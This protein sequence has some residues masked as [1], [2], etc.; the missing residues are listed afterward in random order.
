MRPPSASDKEIDELREL[1]RA[2]LT[3]TRPSAES[4]DVAGILRAVL[5]ASSDAI[6]VKDLEGRYILINSSGARKLGRE[7][8]AVLGRDDGE[9]FPAESSTRMRERDGA[10][11]RSGRPMTY[12][13]EDFVAGGTRVWQS[14]KIPLLDREGQPVG[15][16]GISRDITN[17]RRMEEA[18]LA[19]A[20]QLEAAQAQLVEKE[21]LAA[22][23]QLTA[24]VAHE[25]RNP[26][27]AIVNAVSLLRQ[28][29]D[30]GGVEDSEVLEILREE[31]ERLNRL[32]HDLLEYS[33]PLL[34]HVERSNLLSL[35]KAAIDS[36]LGG[37]CPA[38]AVSVEVDPAITVDTDPRLFQ[39]AVQ[40][41]VQNAMQAMPRG[42]T[43]RVAALAVPGEVRISVSDTGVGVDAA[44]RE[45]LF[46][47]F[48]T[49]RAQGAGLGLALVKRIIEKHRGRIAVDTAPGKGTTVSVF[50][51][52]ASTG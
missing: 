44:A 5:E 13:D 49:T 31:S 32:V 14:T 36:A 29:V 38:L 28:R 46:D 15:I 1:A 26:L 7:V 41:L 23:G 18:L 24:V 21:R 17:E 9:L 10:I 33:R 12:E 20:Q 30:S 50:L 51:P 8:D 35:V 37:G 45:R 16:F 25:I 2:L 19:Q 4:G 34:L 43:L 48:F 11:V 52:D 42:G 47:P 6:F 39:Q 27:G 3:T 40:H 22:V